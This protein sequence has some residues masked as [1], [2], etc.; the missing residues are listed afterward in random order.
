MRV[1]R[2]AYPWGGLDLASPAVPPPL[3]VEGGVSDGVGGVVG[4]GDCFA[5]WAG[6]VGPVATGVGA[7]AP[8]GVGVPVC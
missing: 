8:D 1:E 3:A 2:R 4:G 6:V 7:A 5:G